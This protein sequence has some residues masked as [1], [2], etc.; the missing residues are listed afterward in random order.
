VSDGGSGE[1][2]FSGGEATVAMRLSAAGEHAARRHG[3]A[4]RARPPRPWL[5][6]YGWSVWAVVILILSTVPVEWVFG[7]VPAQ[8]WPWLASAGH[9]V[10][11]GLFAV[12]VAVAGNGAHGWRRAVAVGALAGAVYGP[13]IEV[14]QLAFPWRSFEVRDMAADWVGVAVCVSLLIWVRRRESRQGRRATRRG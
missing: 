12:L 5:V 3:G 14:I 2:E 11:F 9:F 13:L 1:G 10:E 7:V 8:G 4:P 6:R